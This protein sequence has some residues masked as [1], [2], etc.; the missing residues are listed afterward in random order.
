M[1]GRK[2]AVPL[3]LL[4]A[5]LIVI[6]GASACDVDVKP[7]SWPN[8][9]NV[10]NNGVLPVAYACED[11]LEAECYKE[12]VRTIKVVIEVKNGSCW[13]TEFDQNFSYLDL[14]LNVEDVTRYV[15]HVWDRGNCSYIGP[16]GCPDLTMKFR[17]QDIFGC[18]N[19]ADY[20]QCEAVNFRVYGYDGCGKE[21]FNSFDRIRFV[22]ANCK[23]TPAN[24]KE[25]NN[26]KKPK[27]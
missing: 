19:P 18:I 6:P 8:S 24:C 16:D 10:C 20:E 22:P 26:E 7:G 15:S 11:D 23:E 4:L 3:A 2:F 12:N 27:K 5:L 13:Y 25:V 21:L 14:K 17:T 9:I 1:K